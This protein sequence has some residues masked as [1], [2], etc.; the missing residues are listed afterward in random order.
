MMG[1]VTMESHAPSIPVVMMVCV[2]LHPFL[3]VL[4][5]QSFVD[6]PEAIVGTT[7]RLRLPPMS[8]MR[9]AVTLNQARTQVDGIN[10]LLEIAQV[11][12]GVNLYCPM[13]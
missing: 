4:P 13:G 1:H 3:A 8:Y 7:R 11:T 5:S 12:S 10:I 9:F 2:P 6:L